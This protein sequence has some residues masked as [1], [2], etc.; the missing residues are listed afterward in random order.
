M[1]SRTGSLVYA[2][3]STELNCSRGEGD[4]SFTNGVSTLIGGGT[5]KNKREKERTQTRP[6][7]RMKAAIPTPDPSKLDALNTF[8]PCRTSVEP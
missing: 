8:T 7:D 3:T 4:V 6:S 2:A 1:L 5:T